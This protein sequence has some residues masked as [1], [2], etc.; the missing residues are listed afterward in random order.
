MITFRMTIG[1]R[2]SGVYPVYAIIDPDNIVDE[3]DE[4]NNKFST[5]LKVLNKYYL[6]RRLKYPSPDQQIIYYQYEQNIPI[7]LE[8]YDE[9]T[10]KVIDFLSNS[11]IVGK[12][13]A[14]PLWIA[15]WDPGTPTENRPDIYFSSVFEKNNY[16][17]KYIFDTKAYKEYHKDHYNLDPNNPGNL[18]NPQELAFVWGEYW[19]EDTRLE[20]PPDETIPGITRS[21]ELDLQPDCYFTIGRSSL[22]EIDQ[23]AY[24]FWYDLFENRIV[25]CLISFIPGPKWA[26]ALYP[27][28][29]LFEAFYTSA[30]STSFAK[31]MLSFVKTLAEFSDEGVEEAIKNVPLGCILSMI[32]YAFEFHENSEYYIN[33]PIPAAYYEIAALILHSP[34]TL[35]IYD[36]NGNHV[37]VTSSGQIDEQIEG[38]AYSGPDDHPQMMIIVGNREGKHIELKGT[39]N[40]ILN[41]DLGISNGNDHKI[42]Y[43]SNILVNENTIGKIILGNSNPNYLMTI[44]NNGDGTIDD[45]IS[46][47]FYLLP[48]QNQFLSFL[49]LISMMRFGVG[50]NQS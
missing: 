44:D 50:Y 15:W 33:H 18:L 46:P 6:I 41:F 28:T 10:N 49:K 45:T 42:F 17:Y 38:V 35:H 34:A 2:D 23:I 32:E 31:S 1:D 36:Q 3:E 8:L 27:I 11:R 12:I 29:K 20:Y 39:E 43:Y 24:P 47:T 40:G 21:I 13:H 5:Q 9:E 26:T 7:E 30:D 22:F 48:I 19:I 37:G 16:Y 4:T 25:S 14:E